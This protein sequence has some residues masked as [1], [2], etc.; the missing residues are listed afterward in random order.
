MMQGIPAALFVVELEHREFEYPERGPAAARKASLMTDLRAQCPHRLVDHLGAIRAE[1]DEIAILRAAA[2]DYG[3]ESGVG[4]V[5][6]DRRL[7]AVAPFRGL[8]D[9]DV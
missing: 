2:I 5:L 7:Q 9:L 3:F 8:V 4:K 6:D 1:E